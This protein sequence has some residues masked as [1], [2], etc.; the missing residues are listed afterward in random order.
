MCLVKYD[1]K[2]KATYRLCKVFPDIEGAVRC[3][4]IELIK[5]RC[6][7]RI[8]CRIGCRFGYRSVEKY[9]F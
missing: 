4:E 6:S 5:Q 9:E 3:E 8:G 7:D 1:G 2:V